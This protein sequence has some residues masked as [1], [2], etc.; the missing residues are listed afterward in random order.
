MRGRDEGASPA[1][2][3]QGRGAHRT[4]DCGAGTARGAPRTPWRAPV[5]E[6]MESQG[7][8]VPGGASE[9][10]GVGVM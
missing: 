5:S 4:E 3:G 1:E 2:D 6:C 8:P 10:P 9:V 7:A